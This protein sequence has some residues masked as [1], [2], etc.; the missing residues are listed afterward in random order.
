MAT[1]PRYLSLFL[2]LS[3]FL[4]PRPTTHTH[5]VFPCPGCRKEPSVR[6]R[7]ETDEL[8]AAANLDLPEPCNSVNRPRRA[9]AVDRTHA[10]DP[11]DPL[12]ELPSRLRRLGHG[13]AAVFRSSPTWPSQAVGFRSN[14]NIMVQP[15][16]IVAV[17][18]RSSGHV[19]VRLA[20]SH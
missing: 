12:G 13:G 6:I 20:M 3:P 5:A 19:P 10:T 11:A 7:S 16:L 1:R 14:G 15:D 17:H 9:S 4:L 2:S 8:L 18:F